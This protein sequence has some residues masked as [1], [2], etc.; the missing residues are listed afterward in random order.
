MASLWKEA[1]DGEGRAYYAN[2]DTGES[3]WTKPEGFD[4]VLGQAAAG[5]ESIRMSQRVQ[6]WRVEDGEHF[7]CKVTELCTIGILVQTQ[8]SSLA[9]SCA[10]HSFQEQGPL[11]FCAPSRRELTGLRPGPLI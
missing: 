7:K 8:Y 2:T 4:S 11:R 1:Q 10:S 5:A 9:P 3:S 6:R